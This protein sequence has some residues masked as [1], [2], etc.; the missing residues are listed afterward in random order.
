MSITNTNIVA[1]VA[2]VV[3][4]LGLVAMSFASFA[5]ANAATTADLNAQLQALLAQVASLQAQL[6]SSQS[7]SVTFTRD[8][9]IGSTGA[10]V[11]A[12]QNWLIGKGFAISAGATG[13]FGAQ[14]Q[15]ALAAYQAANGITPAAGYFGPI[16]RAKVNAMGG[17]MTG[18][19]TT[20]GGVTLSGG[21]ASLSGFNLIGEE[22]TIR[23]GETATKIATAQFD[24]KDGD[25][26]V[27]RA[28]LEVEASNSGKDIKPWKYIDSVSV[29]DGSKK[30]ATV[31][32][33]DQDAWDDNTSDFSGS[34]N[35]VYKI[36]LTGFHDVVKED[37]DNHELTFSV[38]T[39]STIDSDNEGQ[40]FDVAVPDNGIRAM[41]AE[42]INQYTGDET[43]Y[44][45]VDV[46]AGQN[47]KLTVSEDSS[48]PD[49]GT[50]VADDTD[51]SDDF[52]VFVFKV[53]NSQD[54]DTKIT[55]LEFDVTDGN[56]DT[57]QVVRRA[58][59]D[60]D[61]K[62]YDGDIA[63]GADGG[64]TFSDLDAVV[65]GNSTLKGTVKV[66]LF[67][68]TSVGGYSGDSLTFSLPHGNVTAEGADSGDSVDG[69]DI[70]GTATGNTQSIVVNG[71]VTVAGST[72]SASQT[73]NS[74]DPQASYGTFTLK[75]NV[76]AVGDDVF[77][78]MAI[79]S[80]ANTSGHVAS[81]SSAGVVI[82]T[83]MSAST[84]NSV[85]TKSLS[86]TA[87]TD[88]ALYVIHSGDTETFTATITLNPL[89]VDAD[90]TNF[91]VGL[92][93]VKFSTQDSGD[94]DLQS[95]DVDQ[96]Q[97]EFHTDTLTIAG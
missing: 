6:G 60:I 26:D 58:T 15:A 59:L 38:D 27:Q 96:T 13:Y 94:L 25:I 28:D 21:E 39:V 81:S 3:A 91:Q 66:S 51:T 67:S 93:S 1:K 46:A 55:D 65:S 16:T 50:L 54:A 69:S 20:T 23:E 53:K 34:G 7:A 89:G 19:T 87:D 92:D 32:A 29:W 45:N 40:T 70:T 47:G 33:S 22:G 76:T 42:G 9:T 95:L 97:N 62:T 31:D 79:E 44:V 41:D 74:T 86:S 72:M 49:A 2:A 84:T 83:A 14:T 56:L 24:V 85:V 82:D 4:G 68:D 30:L 17:T 10:D 73:Y 11:T 12:L 61:G 57:D 36:S 78:P 8:L 35:K 52:T 63:T 77:V 64:I 48:D 43:D 88:G 75:F 5:P 71:G 90:L 18:G 37:T 80:T